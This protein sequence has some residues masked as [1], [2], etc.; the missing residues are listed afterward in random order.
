VVEK[1]DGNL[2]VELIPL[3]SIILSVGLE[4]IEE[5]V[6]KKRRVS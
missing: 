1:G 6:G 4:S 5:G 3:V 2:F